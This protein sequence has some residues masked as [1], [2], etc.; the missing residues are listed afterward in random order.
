[1]CFTVL[2]ERQWSAVRKNHH[3]GA[4]PEPPRAP[5]RAQ[6]AHSTQ[7]DEACCRRAGFSAAPGNNL[8]A[9]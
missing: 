6:T 8:R 2:A 5:L 1:M 4:A 3:L 7:H 9:S